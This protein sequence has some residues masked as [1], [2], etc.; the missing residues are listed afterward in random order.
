MSSRSGGRAVLGAFAAVAMF[1][2]AACGGGPTSSGTAPD[3]GGDGA[4]PVTIEHKYGS[5]TI[6]AKPQRVVTLGY[7]DQ[8]AVIALGTVPVGTSEWYGDQPGALF[9]WAAEKLGGAPLP[10]VLP[11]SQTVDF[12]RVA[13]LAPDLILALYAGLEQGDYEKLSAIAPTV[14]PP[15]GVPN[16]GIP[17]DTQT[18]IVGTALGKP[19]EAAVLV[20]EVK[21]KI[22]EVKAAHPEYAGKTALVANQFSD[23]WYAYSTEDQRGRLLTELGFTVNPEI[24]A[25]AGGQFSTP[26][27]FERADLIDADALIWVMFDSEQEPKVRANPSYA[28]TRAAKEGRDVFVV[29][30]GS[31]GLEPMIGFLTV[32]SLPPL[33]DAL[34]AHLDALLDGDPATR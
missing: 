27:S 7:T 20:K 12:E 6:P 19:A 5:T 23:Q 25:L 30:T 11:V 24:D 13:A 8:D 34:P 2:L 33:L 32:L 21:D 15:A 1:L 22:A 4:F 3:T 14:V 16:Y 10:T 31:T 18:E 28:A 26:I 17:W 9:P 29:P